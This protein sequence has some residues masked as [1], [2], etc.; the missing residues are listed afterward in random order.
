M[1]RAP[2]GMG[3]RCASHPLSGR[4]NWLIAVIAAVGGLL[5]GYD[6]GVISGALLYT[7]DDLSAGTFEPELIVSALPAGAL[8]GVLASGWLADRIS[9]RR[10]KIISGPVYFVAA[11]GHAFAVNVPMLV[12]FRFLLGFS[13]GP[14]RRDRLPASR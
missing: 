1:V 12:A 3:R 2:V 11:L 10:T 14:R 8:V 5:F 13:V 6:T 9:W 4:H 7:K